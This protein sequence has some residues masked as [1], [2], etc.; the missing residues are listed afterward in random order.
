MVDRRYPCRCCGFWT[1]SDPQT[2]NYEVCPVCFWEDDAVQNADPEYE[3][4]TNRVSLSEARGKYIRIG[5]CEKRSV[6]SVRSP[7]AAEFP[8]VPVLYGLEEERAAEVRRGLKIQILAVVRAMRAGEQ[9]A[10]RPRAERVGFAAPA[11]T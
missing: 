5:D 11:F 10:C 8:P 1:L 7:M 4:G 9:A 3:G 2:G 6:G